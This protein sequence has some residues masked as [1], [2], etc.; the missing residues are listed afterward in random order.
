MPEFEHV[1][2]GMV[3]NRGK[4]EG[5]GSWKESGGWDSRSSQW[6]SGGLDGDWEGWEGWEGREDWDKWEKSPNAPVN[7]KWH[8][9]K[10]GFEAGYSAA[11]KNAEQTQGVACLK[12]VMEKWKMASEVVKKKRKHNW[13]EYTKADLDETPLFVV[14]LGEGEDEVQP[15]PD[16]FRKKKSY[17]YST[18]T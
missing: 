4:W 13:I 1:V 7:Q 18:R 6:K 11:M 8:V 16:E 14:K 3:V 2:L 9:W 17:N 12:Y 10:D 15:Y 5:G